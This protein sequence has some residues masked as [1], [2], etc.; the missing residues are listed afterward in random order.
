[1]GGLSLRRR[2]P[3]RR[4]WI[5]GGWPSQTTRRRQSAADGHVARQSED[6]GAHA[7]QRRDVPGKWR[8]T[9]ERSPFGAVS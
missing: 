3:H 2:L 9:P 4:T 6:R 8:T 5:G 1:M 7:T